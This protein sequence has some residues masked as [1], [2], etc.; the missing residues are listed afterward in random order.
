MGYLVDTNVLVYRFDSRDAAKQERATGFLR[1]GL[2]S[3]EARIPHQAILE[4]VAATTRPLRKDPEVSLLELGEAAREAEELMAQFPVLYP[5]DG[6]LRLALRGWCTY[7]L[8][9]FDAHIW[10]YAEYYGLETLYS[11]DFQHGRRYGKV[12]VIDPFIG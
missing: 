5:T 9:W 1:E 11:E 7:R 8:N 2:E 4:F 6:V 3:G 12:R 10:A